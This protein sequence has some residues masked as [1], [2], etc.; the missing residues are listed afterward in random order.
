MLVIG[1]SNT[2]VVIKLVLR[3]EPSSSALPAGEWQNRASRE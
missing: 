3:R 1:N 2:G